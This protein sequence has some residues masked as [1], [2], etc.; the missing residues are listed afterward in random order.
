MLVGLKLLRFL[1]AA[2]FHVKLLLAKTLAEVDV[3]A[4][5]AGSVGVS[6]VMQL[7]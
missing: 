7:F 5:V 1:F 2:F 6:R 3:A 4:V